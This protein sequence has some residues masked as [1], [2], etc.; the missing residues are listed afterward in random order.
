MRIIQG[1]Y[2][3]Q[4]G[5]P[6]A[7]TSKSA[8]VGGATKLTGEAGVAQSS[9]TE[10]VTISAKARELADQSAAADTDKV[11]RLRDAIQA[12]TFQIDPQA[13]ANR[14]VAGD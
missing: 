10:N 4:N 6:V 5:A 1:G 14:I 7:S 3:Q 12:G 11:G 9:S 8:A 2:G 13:I